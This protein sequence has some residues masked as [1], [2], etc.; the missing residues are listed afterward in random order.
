MD[1]YNRTYFAQGVAHLLIYQTTNGNM[2]VN[3]TYHTSDRFPLGEFV[4]KVREAESVRKLETW[5]K[6]KF[7]SIGF[8]LEKADQPW[9]SLYYIIKEYAEKN[10]GALPKAT[11]RTKDNVL[12]GAWVRQQVFTFRHLSKKKQKLLR[13]IGIGPNGGR[14]L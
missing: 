2:D 12:I 10:N 5:Q 3:E 7:K 14:M 8:A 11:E 9:E 1:I 6:E 13:E 4:L